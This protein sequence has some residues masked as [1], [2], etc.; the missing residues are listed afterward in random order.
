MNFADHFSRSK[1]KSP[2]A[3]SLLYPTLFHVFAAIVLSSVTGTLPIKH[4]I[5][6]C[7]VGEA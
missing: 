2:L 4:Q 7:V 6:K 5:I 3:D 1:K